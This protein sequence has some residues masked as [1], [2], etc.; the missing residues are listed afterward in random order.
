M[1]TVLVVEDEVLIAAMAQT[2]LEE[3]G[4]AVVVAANAD[5]AIRILETRSDIHTVFTDVN[6]PGS[7]DGAK[8]A[9]AVRDRWPPVNIIVTS[10]RPYPSSLPADMLFINKPYE[11]SKVISAIRAF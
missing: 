9:L 8:L 2:D 1:Q 5:E 6:M 3:A 4:F 10:G 11:I 7:M